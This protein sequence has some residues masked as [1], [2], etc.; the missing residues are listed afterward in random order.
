MSHSGSNAPQESQYVLVQ[1]DTE[2]PNGKV[3]APG[4][5]IS[6]DVVDDQ[7]VITADA[8]GPLPL[9]VESG[10]LFRDLGGEL[11]LTLDSPS[12][13]VLTSP[14]DPVLVHLPNNPQDGPDKCF[15]ILNLCGEGV[16]VDVLHDNGPLNGE[17]PQ[18]TPMVGHGSV[19]KVRAAGFLWYIVG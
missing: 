8:A 18:P 14:V 4:A 16:A 2:L 9:A 5:G 3:L 11:V 10:S 1:A 15:T 12:F 7:V 19:L 17:G 6:V 13:I